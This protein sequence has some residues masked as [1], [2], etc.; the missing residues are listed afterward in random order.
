MEQACCGQEREERSVWV[1]KSKCE[2]SSGEISPERQVG[3]RSSQEPGEKFVS[4]SKFT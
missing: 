1:E 4:H 2:E 3:I